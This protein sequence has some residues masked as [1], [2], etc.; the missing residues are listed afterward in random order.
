MVAMLDLVEPV[1]EALYQGRGKP[2]L[3]KG[4][5]AKLGQGCGNCRRLVPT[6]PA[7]SVLTSRFGSWDDI[8]VAPDG[9]RSLCVPCAWAYRQVDLRRSV[10]LVTAEPSVTHP[11]PAQVRSLLDTALASD[12]ALIVPLSGKR[13]VAPRAR[14]GCLTTDSGALVW[15]ASHRRL[16]RLAMQLRAWGFREQG[17]DEPSPPFDT[18]VRIDPDLHQQVQRAWAGFEPARADKTMLGVYQRLTREKT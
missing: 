5:V 15:S 11:D 14:W 8:S 7:S 10:T 1:T 18:L 4:G 12:V 17:L 13:I 6:V 16:L 3:D 2:I 9:T